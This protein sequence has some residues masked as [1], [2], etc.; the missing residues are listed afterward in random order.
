[1]E[2]NGC[3]IQ[4][5]CYINCVFSSTKY[6][7]DVTQQYFHLEAFQINLWDFLWEITS[8]LC[9]QSLSVSCLQVYMP[10]VAN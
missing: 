7:T 4:I 1:M 8:E 3:P 5:F 9:S 2:S 6:G 10:G